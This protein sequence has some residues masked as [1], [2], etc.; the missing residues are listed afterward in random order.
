MLGKYSALG[1]SPRKE[2]NFK[3][4]ETGLRAKTIK[5]HRDF[6]KLYL[7]STISCQARS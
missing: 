4:A 2:K 1:L 3:E 7:N 6:S 5:V